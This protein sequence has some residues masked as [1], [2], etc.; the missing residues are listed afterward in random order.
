MKKSLYIL[1]LIFGLIIAQ[2]KPLAVE[3][4]GFDAV[5]KNASVVLSWSTASETQNIGFILERKIDSLANWNP[6]VSYLTEDAL[7][8][9][10]TVSTQSDYSFRDSSV[11]SGK[12]Y[13]YRISGIDE[14][15]NVGILDSLFISIV[16]TRI[17]QIIPNDFNFKA[18]PNPFNPQI[19]CAMHYNESRNSVVDIFNTQGVLVKQLINSYLGPGMHQVT[20][21]ASNMPSGIYVIMVK[22]DEFM[23]SQKVILMK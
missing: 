7:L 3:F 11:T 10:G 19:V 22:A 13:F 20:W 14:A 23:H 5:A 8:G 9:Q 6:F 17:G 1:L 18:Y 15:N 2:A 4:M 12:T 21:D 16:E